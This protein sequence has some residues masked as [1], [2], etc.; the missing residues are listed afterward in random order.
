[1]ICVSLMSGDLGKL[2]KDI[3]AAA[4]VADLIEIRLDYLPDTTDIGGILAKR[5]KPVIVTYRRVEDGGLYDGDDRVRIG[6]LQKAAEQGADYVDIE[7]D[8]AAEL[9]E[10]SSKLIVSYHNFKETPSDLLAIHNE[11]VAAG[12]HI[13]K[14][15]VMANDIGDNLR[16]FDLLKRVE[17]STVAFCMGELG[18]ISRIIGRKF[19]SKITY[20]ALAK[21]SETAAGQLPA[22]E[23]RH[24]YH[25]DRIEPTTAVYGVI[26]NPVAHSMS[27]AIHNAAFAHVGIDA[28]YLP[29]KVE[30]PVIFVNSFKA[31]DA[32]GY[33]VTIPHKET[34][35]PAMDELDPVAREIGA[36]NTV[37]NRDGRLIGYNTDYLAAIGE[38]EKVTRLEGK[39]AVMIGAG[40]GAR[41]IAFGLKQKGVDLTVTDIVPEKACKL[42]EAVGCAWIEHS[43]LSKPDADVLLNA[44]PVGMHPNVDRTPIP[45]AWLRPEMVVFDIVYNP[46][47]TRLLREA[48]LAGCRTVSGFSM[49]VSQA[50]AQFELWTGRPAPAEVMADVVRKKLA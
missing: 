34:I 44:T 4:P 43:K 30:E 11:A 5:P 15:A 22:R 32:Q 50:V 49:F 46:M 8:A 39:R 48:R 45:A 9:R 40:G 6:A 21:G 1:M 25:Y 17:T 10:L 37:V 13:V 47:E 28:V 26:A 23:L 3:A 41:A 12:A 24:L 29:F 27:P 7:L 35:M 33:S 42:A 31:I 2:R 20:A 36:I 19:G 14:I 16:V 38:L 18:L